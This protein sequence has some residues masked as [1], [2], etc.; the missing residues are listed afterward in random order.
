MGVHL[1]LSPYI[2]RSEKAFILFEGLIND[3]E[4]LFPVIGHPAMDIY[5]IRVV[6]AVDLRGYVQIFDDLPCFLLKP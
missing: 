3:I 1:L 4:H 6:I 5:V 2:D